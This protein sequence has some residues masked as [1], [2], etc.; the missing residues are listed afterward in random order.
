M[1][2]RFEKIINIPTI[3]VLIFL[4]PQF[5]S[6]QS[7]QGN[8]Y[9]NAIHRV[10]S[11]LDQGLSL[12]EAILILSKEASE[13]VLKRSINS[14]DYVQKLADM[15]SQ[16]QR[17]FGNAKSHEKRIE[18]LNRYFF[19]ELDFKAD[20][21]DSNGFNP[22]NLFLNTVLDR[23]TGY[24][25]SLSIP[26][27]CLADRLKLPIFGVPAPGHFFVRYNAGRSRMNIETTSS[28]VV[29]TDEFYKKKYNLPPAHSFYLKNLNVKHVVGIFLNN[30]GN[31][32]RRSGFPEKGLEAL[33]GAVR[34]NP[35]YPEARSNLGSVYL[36]KGLAKAALRQH[37]RAVSLNK[38]MA[39]FRLNLASALF[40]NKLYD[41]SLAETRNAASLNPNFPG[42]HMRLGLIY[43]TQKK[44]SLAIR[45]YEQALG[46]W[47]DAAQIYLF[48]G[49]IYKILKDDDKAIH[50]YKSSIRQSPPSLEPYINL[51]NIYIA[52]KAYDEAI[53]VYLQAL[54]KRPDHA[55]IYVN[56]G[57]LNREKG[58]P[59]LAR[60]AF[61]KALS[62]NPEL[63][64]AHFNYAVLLSDSDENIDQAIDAFF[65]ALKYNPKMVSAY[66]SL[67]LIYQ[68]KKQDLIAALSCY[69][70]AI[71]LNP[72][73]I[74]AYLAKGTVLIAQE[75][76][77]EAQA[78]L[79]HARR[80]DPASEMAC[81]NLGLVY[82]KKGLIAKQM[83]AFYKVV[84]INPENAAAYH[85]L[86]IIYYK[87][88]DYKKALTYAENAK[89]L[90]LSVDPGLW[91]ILQTHRN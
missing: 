30:L 18:I 89:M 15:T 38:N 68:H 62:L 2:T 74:E 23:K 17:R 82:G 78:T 42:I 26:Y 76:L 35:D 9:R 29:L 66:L 12:E 60:E 49:N 20:L 72:K 7:Q 1:L 31:T 4:L 5:S 43:M 44:Y 70:R 86:A 6:G 34:L 67:G 25:L 58:N 53:R 88:E 11:T 73:I 27:L 24:C 16:V 69:E 37:L 90:G 45:A 19:K 46:R 8:T 51:A 81:F 75:K 47:Q 79:E 21:A 57:N 55:E 50:A 48:L 80:L 84:S 59:A 63:A 33:E 83:E 52:R 40:A 28:G 91:R 41:E 54:K 56:L 71:D 13:D 10:I 36:E 14:A 3:F 32:Y 77:D 87:R 64:S 61:K 22:E 65:K 85:N 39:E